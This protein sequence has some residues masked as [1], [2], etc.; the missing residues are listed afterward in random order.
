[1]TLNLNRYRLA[2]K[3]I[4]A[5]FLTRQPEANRIEL[6]S[7]IAVTIN[8]PI[9]AVGHY[10]LELEGTSPG[11]RESIDRLIKFYDIDKLEGEQVND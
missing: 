9:I 6:M 10:M 11:L 4:V 2:C 1:M 3:P 8:C 5:G 7:V